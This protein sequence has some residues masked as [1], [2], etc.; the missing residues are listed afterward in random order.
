MDRVIEGKLLHDII[1][2]Y[3]RFDIFDLR[4]NVVPQQPMRETDLSDIEAGVFEAA[5]TASPAASPSA[6]PPP[7]VPAAPKPE[8]DPIPLPETLASPRPPMARQEPLAPSSPQ[9]AIA[10]VP[11]QATPPSKPA[12]PV[13]LAAVDFRDGAGDAPPP[14]QPPVSKP[15][16]EPTA[17]LLPP[18]PGLRD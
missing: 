15:R 1:G 9:P 14:A 12:E 13:A 10:G 6:E 7:L 17:S 11:L 4:V 2:H 16:S 18:P 5:E 8:P 3:N